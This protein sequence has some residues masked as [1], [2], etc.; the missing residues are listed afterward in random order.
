MQL[1]T[2]VDEVPSGDDWLHEVKFDGYRMLCRIDDGKVSFLTRHG[3]DWTDRVSSLTRAAAGLPCQSALLDGEV[4]VLDD[5]GVS[6]FGALQDALSRQDTSRLIYFAFDLL[7]LDGADLTAMP[8]IERKQ[9]LSSRCLNPTASPTDR[10]AIA[11]TCAAKA[12]GCLGQSLRSSA[13]KASYRN[14]PSVYTASG[15]SR[16][17]LE[18]QMSRS[19]RN[20]SSSASPIPPAV[21][22]VLARC[23][24]V[25]TARTKN[26]FTPAKS[27]PA[28]T[29]MP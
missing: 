10:Y 17:W 15:R 24:W 29:P 5:S 8:L 1:A 2:L 27:A 11:M 18:N 6:D 25:I 20:S 28:S 26:C 12:T 21:A 13:S 3:L 16:E 4:V 7:H 23:F 14:A 9:R 22:P 19:A